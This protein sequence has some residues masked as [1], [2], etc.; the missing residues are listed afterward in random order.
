MNDYLAVD[1]GLGVHLATTVMLAFGLGTLAG[2][3][4]GGVVGQRLYNTAPWLMTTAMGRGAT[5]SAWSETRTLWSQSA[6]KIKA[7]FVALDVRLVTWTILADWVS[8]S[9]EPCFDFKISS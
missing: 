7:I 9:I 4:L 5:L 2:V 6:R 1:K 3:A 8:S